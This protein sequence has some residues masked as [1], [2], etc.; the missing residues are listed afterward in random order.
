MTGILSGLRVLDLSRGV[1]GPMTTMLMADHEAHVTRILPPN[2]DP[3]ADHAGYRVWQ[4][5]KAVLTLDLKDDA[6]RDRFLRMVDEADVV[7][8]SFSPGV[9]DR[10]GIDYLTLSRR[11]PALIYLSITGYG[12]GTA[13]ADRPGYD[14]LVAARTGLQWEQRGWPEGCEYHMSRAEGFAPDIEVP[15]EWVQGPA[16]PG[17]VF[18]ASTWPSLGAFFAASV[19]FNAAL[20]ARGLTGRGQHVETSLLQGAMAAAWAV[21]QRAENPDA[22]DFATWI[23]GSRSPKGHF[24][25]ADG[26]WIHHWVPNPRFLIGASETVENAA[27]LNVHDDPDRFGFGPEELLVMM[28]YQEDLMERVGRFDADY[29]VNAAAEAKLPI[30]ICRPVEE[31]LNDPLLLDDGCVIE[32]EDAEL[33][34]I[35]Q[36]GTTYALSACP[37]TIT[38]RV[39]DKAPRPELPPIEAADEALATMKGKGPLAGVRV[40]EFGLAVAGPYGTQLLSDLG[41]EVIKVNT[42]YDSYWHR[43]SISFACNRGKRS[44]ALNL[45]DPRSKAI[46]RKLVESGDIVQHNMR[47]GAA[48]R[49]GIDYESLK[50]I[51]PALIY[52][53]TR[54]FERG[55]REA[56]PGNDQTGACLAGIQYE[57]GGI[58]RGGK[59][60]WALTAF[61]DTGNGFLSAIAMIQALIHR[62]RTGEGQFVDTSIINASLLNTSFAY[63]F[64][65]G[66][67]PER[68]RIDAEQTGFNALCRLYETASGWLCIVAL[69]DAH[70]RALSGVPGLEA[71]ARDQR[72]ATPAS[73]REN[74]EELADRLGD[75]LR[76]ADAAHWRDAFDAAG[77]PCEISDPEF[78]LTMF[79]NAEFKERGWVAGFEHGQVGYFEQ[80]GLCVDLSETPGAVQR[81]PLTSGEESRTVLAE[82]G[83][84]VSEID[85]LVADGVIVVPDQ[86]RGSP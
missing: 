25:C 38:G 79:D 50:A 11:N 44:I 75:L 23:F 48:T 41:A 1:A 51:N 15:Y 74:D 27:K 17:P 4:R 21:W 28:H 13:D 57:D 20:R 42:T 58:A 29:W 14:A 22:P 73:R 86:G 68:P 24:L 5:G 56:L 49:L 9:T 7:V 33:G 6:G 64:P 16:R 85:A 12:R 63:A 35:R 54:G 72:F 40:I 82:F 81:G 43:S 18:P 46:V 77:V 65:D 37:A 45:K 36:V 80:P 55:P 67:G 47:Y 59:P 61:G 69:D 66:T 70:W 53:H 30:Q 31:A 3:F 84:T 52:C 26:R 39:P 78:P 76:T 71:I 19:G 2:G 8:E 62:D 34:P 60:M 83:Y 32:L 10:L